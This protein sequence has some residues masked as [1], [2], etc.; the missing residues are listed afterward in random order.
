MLS[1]R[2]GLIKLRLLFL[3]SLVDGLDKVYHDYRST[4]IR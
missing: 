2:I 3:N 1:D 4:H